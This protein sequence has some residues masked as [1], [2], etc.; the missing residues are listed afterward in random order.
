[1]TVDVLEG[2]G[3]KMKRFTFKNSHLGGYV[4]IEVSAANEKM[5]RLII[6]KTIKDIAKWELINE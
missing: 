4:K 3:F 2:L 1:M 5:A 6:G